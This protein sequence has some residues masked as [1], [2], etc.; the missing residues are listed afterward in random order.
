MAAAETIVSRRAPVRR[1]IAPAG[2]ETTRIA[3]LATERI[4]PVCA[5]V[6]E[7]RSANDG[8]SGATADHDISPT[9]LAPYSRNTTVRL[10]T[11][12]VAL[13]RGRRRGQIS[14]RA[15]AISGRAI[16]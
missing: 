2:M 13:G 7:N 16:R 15:A 8:K 12:S 9:R 1:I 5:S 4:G 6:S 10:M 14:E 11:G 3:R